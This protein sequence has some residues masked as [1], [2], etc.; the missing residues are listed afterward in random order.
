M[1]HAVFTL[2]LI[3]LLGRL[4][5]PV[6]AGP[7]GGHAAG[8]STDV[9]LFWREGCPHCE[10]EIEFLDRLAAAEPRVR[11]QRF[12]IIR[13]RENRELLV[14]VG[15]TL[16]TD[17]GYVPVTVIGDQVWVGYLDDATTG[18]ELRSRVQTCLRD[19]CPDS[20]R[21]LVTE[22]RV[23][24][25]PTGT[26]PSGE[27]A[28][29]VAKGAPASVHVPALGEINLRD[30]SLPALTVVLGGLDGFNP[31]AMW[32]LVFLLGLLVGMQDRLRMWI[33]GT[34]FI[35][36][37]ALVYLAFMAAWLNLLLFVGMLVWVRVLIGLVALAGGGYNL[38][39]YVLNRGE[40]CKITAPR[41]RRRIFERLREL[42]GRR[43]FYVA[44]AGIVALAFLVN[45]VELLCSAGIPAVYTQV[46]AMNHLP[47]WQY[48]SYLLLY[49]VVYM[50]DDLVVFLLAMA[51][52][53]VAGL[54]ARYTRYSHL[55][56]GALLCV[57]GAL[58]LLRP[59]W[60]AFG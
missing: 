7:A 30:L 27:P 54:T 11:V 8:A 10:R 52:L 48:Y 9:Y 46:L 51:T 39:E 14:R 15:K 25:Q 58:L 23:P 26:Q 42:S 49:I 60:L 36:T 53:R 28:R 41:A 2:A 50:L 29:A 37:S 38:R 33:L 21:A 59:E 16:D 5:P 12:E 47:A 20:V 13:N 35:A 31:C 1:R 18:A 24:P 43:E 3:L 17:I 4:A 44:L 6:L 57:I 40:I 34:A 56:G 19:G 22:T 32:A 55:V 45:L